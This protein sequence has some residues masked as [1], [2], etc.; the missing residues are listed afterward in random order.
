MTLG[1]GIDLPEPVLLD[2][3]ADGRARAL[4]SIHAEVH[5]RGRPLLLVPGLGCGA[6]VWATMVAALRGGFELHAITLGG[7]AGAPAVPGPLL[8]RWRADLLAYLRRWAPDRPVVVGH[9]LGAFLALAAAI[10]GGDEVAGVVCVDGVPAIAGL[11]DPGVD[12]VALAAV[13]RSRHLALAPQDHAAWWSA[14]LGAMITAPEVAA[15]V[16]ETAMRSDR[17]AVAAAMAEVLIADLRD[18]LSRIAA[19]V[20]A[21]AGLGATASPS[22]RRRRLAAFAA[23]FA[24]LTRCELLVL[25]RA[26]HFVMLDAPSRVH[27]AIVDFARRHGS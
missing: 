18:E 12:L 9:S 27:A 19:P 1:C 4:G 13:Q 14:S 8:P 21:I 16:V 17:E 2:L 25:E 7:F 15:R 20:L 3:P 26:R 23:T 6:H 22:E 10:D 11:A 24:P 5:G